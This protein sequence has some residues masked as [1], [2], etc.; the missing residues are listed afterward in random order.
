[1][2]TRPR[3][4]GPRH[5]LN[6]FF[7]PFTTLSCVSAVFGSSTRRTAMAS[8]KK[9]SNDEIKVARYRQEVMRPR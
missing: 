6:Y 5:E 7:S 8:Q 1:M 2:S 3:A 4:N 9:D